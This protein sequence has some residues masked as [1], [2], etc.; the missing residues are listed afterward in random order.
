[1]TKTVALIGKP[2]EE[3]GRLV[4]RSTANGITIEGDMSP[5]DMALA[6]ACLSAYAAKTAMENGE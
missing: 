3:T 4:V 5:E 6:G 1:M 2:A